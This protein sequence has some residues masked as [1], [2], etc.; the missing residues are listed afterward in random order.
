MTVTESQ[1]CDI[2]HTSVTLGH[3][4]RVISQVTVTACDEVVI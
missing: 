1:R 4:T 2:C 3:V